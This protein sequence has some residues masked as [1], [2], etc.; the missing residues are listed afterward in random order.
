MVRL[1]GAE[2]E[3]GKGSRAGNLPFWFLCSAK[4]EVETGKRSRA[5][6]LPFWF[7]FHSFQTEAQGQI[8]NVESEVIVW[9]GSSGG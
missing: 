4:A 3:T 7:L 1:F 5:G 2:V 6:N 9:P 8:K